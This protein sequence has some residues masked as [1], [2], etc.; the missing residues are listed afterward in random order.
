MNRDRMRN[1]LI[2]AILAGGCGEVSGPPGTPAGLSRVGG[3]GQQATVATTLPIP[4]S[5]RVRDS[6]GSGVAG[7]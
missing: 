2:L 3:D 1:L 7:T 4:I 5:V 6:R